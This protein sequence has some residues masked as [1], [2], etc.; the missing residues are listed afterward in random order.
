MKHC[1]DQTHLIYVPF[2]CWIIDKNIYFMTI[3]IIV[4][5][6]YLLRRW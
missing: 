6:S 4:D 1:I 2:A 5:F 3:I